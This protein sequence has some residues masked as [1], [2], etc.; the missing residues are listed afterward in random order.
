MR[1]LENFAHVDSCDYL[2]TLCIIQTPRTT[3]SKPFEGEKESMRDELL[4]SKEEQYEF[5][6][7]E[8]ISRGEIMKDLGQSLL[9]P[10]KTSDYLP[11]PRQ[12]NMVSAAD[13]RAAQ[14]SQ[15]AKRSDLRGLEEAIAETGTPSLKTLQEDRS[16]GVKL[17]HMTSVEEGK[18][19]DHPE[20]AH[21]ELS[22]KLKRADTPPDPRR[23]LMR[24][25]RAA[26]WGA[27]TVAEK[28]IVIVFTAMCKVRLGW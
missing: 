12:A 22:P 4:E 13:Q 21:D 5:G 9:K 16:E 14:L 3:P 15:L 17:E 26:E 23:A 6:S 8:T 20:K 18:L 10:I 1:W 28:D 27:L 11:E 19:L 25:V 24:D 2:C 7:A